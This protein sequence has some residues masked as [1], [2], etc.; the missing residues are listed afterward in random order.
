M[1]K[2]VTSKIGLLQDGNASL[3]S[4]CCMSFISCPSPELLLNM[5]RDSLDNGYYGVEFLQ[6]FP[7]DIWALRPVS[8]LK[9]Y[10]KIAMSTY[11]TKCTLI[12]LIAASIPRSIGV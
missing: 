9:L 7:I 1:G 11:L 3:V 2:D 10:I 6:E 12:S 8:Y 4:G 5:L